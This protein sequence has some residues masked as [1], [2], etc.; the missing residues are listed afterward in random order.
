MIDRLTY[1]QTDP[2]ALPGARV[3]RELFVNNGRHELLVF[4]SQYMTLTVKQSLAFYKN[5]FQLQA[6]Y[7]ILSSMF[8]QHAPI[9]TD[10]WVE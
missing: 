1:M 3:K 6:S 9:S 4:N 2:N 10:S 7:P 5:K 8:Q